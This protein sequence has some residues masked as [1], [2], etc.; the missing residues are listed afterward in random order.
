MKKNIFILLL[1]CQTLTAVTAQSKTD[2]KIANTF[3]IQ[4]KG[5]WDYL[6]IN[7]NRLYVSHSSQVN[8]LDK[9]TGDSVGV[10]ANTMG[11]H[12]IA[13]MPAL[14]KGYTSNGRT[15]NVSVFDLKTNVVLNQIPTGENPDAI[16]YE[17]FSKTIIT[18]NGKS[19]DLSI[20]D[21]SSNA[22]IATIAV[23]GKPETLV[24]NE[25]GLV[26]VNIED[27]NE[28]LVI[29]I[30]SK[31]IVNTWSL[32]TAEAPRGLAI[33]TTNNLLFVGCDEALVVLKA[34]NGEIID[35]IRIGEGCDGV[36]YD[37]ILKYIFASNGE[38]TLTIIEEKS[39]FTFVVLANLPT[40]KA[41]RTICLD[42]ETHTVYLP[43]SEFEPRLPT[44]DPKARQKTKAGTFQ[45]I[46][47]K[48]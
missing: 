47:I 32:G 15:N 48:Q 22:V 12:G 13:F 9:I 24:S 3:H 40:K 39:P 8:V 5:G 19:N 4:S 34:Q 37:K 42:E 30:L 36:V 14:G 33:D 25:K 6:A 7:S 46:V 41:A 18:C 44:D 27:K 43:T 23:S 20:I 29:D 16:M 31:K 17:P 11:V 28:V 26:Y 21:P 45:V 10:V 38:G 1:L 2:F 35:K